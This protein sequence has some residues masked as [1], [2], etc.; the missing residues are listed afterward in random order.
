MLSSCFL[1]PFKR[2]MQTWRLNSL[3]EI[4]LTMFFYF[5]IIWHQQHELWAHKSKMKRNIFKLSLIS[6]LKKLMQVRIWSILSIPPI[7]LL[8]AIIMHGDKN[9]SRATFSSPAHLQMQAA[10][11]TAFIASSTSPHKIGSDGVKDISLVWKTTFF[12]SMS[13]THHDFSATF[14]VGVQKVI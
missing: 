3:I 13:A 8:Q 7:N 1:P 10:P 2:E 9:S 6:F 12:L 11:L 5:I 14:V 4:I